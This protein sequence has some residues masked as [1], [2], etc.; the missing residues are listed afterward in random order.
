MNWL[1]PALDA[2]GK[3]PSKESVVEAAVTTGADAVGRGALL[4]RPEH[5]RYKDDSWLWLSEQVQTV[6]EATQ[7]VRPFPSHLNYLHDLNDAWNECPMLL[8]P[9]SRRMM[10]TWLFAGLTL[11]EV[12]YW[13][14]HCAIWQGKV[15]GDGAMVIDKRMLWIEEHQ[16]DNGLMLPHNT[17]RTHESLVGRI[18][19]PLTNSYVFAAPSGSHVVRSYTPSIY[20]GDEYAFHTDPEGTYKALMAL[21]EKGKHVRIVL[22]T[23]SGG[24]VGV[25]AKICAEVGFTRFS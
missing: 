1:E 5:Q 14:N 7:Q 23:T 2:I 15:E 20:I 19:Y 24:P 9:K 12:R 22:I 4:G 6:D 16:V 18:T 13:R 3:A 11:F 25:V 8:V 21:A 10:V 17:V